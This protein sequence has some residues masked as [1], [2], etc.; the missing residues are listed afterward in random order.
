M[1]TVPMSP[2]AI[3]V[4]A[5]ARKAGHKITFIPDKVCREGSTV[6]YWRET[7]RFTDVEVTAKGEVFEEFYGETL[8]DH[9]PF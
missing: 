9:M 7:E 6:A 8:S 4:I 3:K 5:A 1:R 2:K